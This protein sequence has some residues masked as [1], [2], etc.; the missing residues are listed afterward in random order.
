MALGRA[1]EIEEV[2][3]ILLK[4]ETRGEP[5]ALRALAFARGD[6]ELF[7]QAITRFEE[8]GL[9]WHAAQT[10]DLTGKASRQSG[11]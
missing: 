4:P 11:A 5:F 10:R 7:Q 1:A 3:P 9:D 2:A 8:M 6:T